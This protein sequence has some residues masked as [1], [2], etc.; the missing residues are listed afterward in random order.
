MLDARNRELHQ[1]IAE[2]IRRQP[3]LLRQVQDTLDRWLRETNPSDPGRDS[4]VE[5]RQMLIEQ[6]LD[7]LLDF[8]ISDDEEANR[9]RQSTPFVGILTEKARLAVIRKY[10]AFRN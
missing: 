1:L 4:L 9:L 5:W 6:P 8:I 3:A 10:D 2:E 7:I